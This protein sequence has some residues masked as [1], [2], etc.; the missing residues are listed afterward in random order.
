MDQYYPCGKVEPGSKRDRA[1]TYGED[2]YAR[3]LAREKG[4]R[5]A[6]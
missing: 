5:I 1:I 4:L 6:E 3:K 2:R